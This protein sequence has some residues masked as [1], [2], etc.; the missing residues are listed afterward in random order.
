M[1]F[2]IIPIVCIIIVCLWYTRFLKERNE[3]ENIKEK[4]GG[5]LFI[6][7]L[8]GIEGTFISVIILAIFNLSIG[9]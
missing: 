9:R 2:F 7:I 8:A 4:I 5:Y 6:M 3:K 1:K